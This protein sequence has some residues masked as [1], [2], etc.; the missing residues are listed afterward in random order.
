[1]LSQEKNQKLFLKRRTFNKL[2]L[3]WGIILIASALHIFLQIILGSYIADR[4]MTN[5]PLTTQASLVFLT[6]TFS[7]GI[8]CL[9]FQSG[10]ILQNLREKVLVIYLAA[11]LF[12]L[13][14]ILFFRIPYSSVFLFYGVTLQIFLGAFVIMIFERFNGPIIGLTEQTILDVGHLISSGSTR[15]ILPTMSNLSEL[16]L[17]V[18]TESELTSPEWSNFLMNCAASSIAIEGQINFIERISGKVDLDHLSFHKLQQLL[19]KNRYLPVKR[20]IDLLFSAC[21]LIFLMPIMLLIAIFIRLESPGPI[22]FLQHRVGQG[23][24]PFTIYKFRTMQNA[25]ES[26]RAK[27]TEKYDTRVTRIGK[28]LRKAHLDELP[29]LWNV[30]IGDMSL[31]GP[32]P[33]QLELI[34][35]IQKDIPLFSLRHS[36]RPGI[37]GWAQ[38]RYGYADDIHSTNEKLSYDL[39]YVSNVSTIVDILIAILTVRAVC[40]G[41]GSR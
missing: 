7:V 16:D 23:G 37:T 27:F 8:S 30:M 33:E 15:R 18:L 13:A 31:I 22:L 3:N 41:F 34:G 39:W 11:L 4:S 14:P 36:L 5:L 25:K 28:L 6:L 24:R 12:C 38:V 19:R 17:V 35:P 26:L 32:R 2:L 20:L 10:T 40:T 1:M 9:F 29:Q 21:L